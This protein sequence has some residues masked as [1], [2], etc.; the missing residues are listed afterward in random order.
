MTT[1][2]LLE[3]ATVTSGAITNRID[4]LVARGLVTRE[5][6]P[7]TRRRVLITLTDDG[8]ASIDPASPAM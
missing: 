5:V 7:L 1:R 2:Q 3:S 8:H 6:N 4:G